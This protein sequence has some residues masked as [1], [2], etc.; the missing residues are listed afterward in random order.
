MGFLIDKYKD[1][2]RLLTEHDQSTNQFPR[3]LNGTFEDADVYIKCKNDIR[4]YYFGRSILEVYCPSV[5]RGMGIVRTI[6]R[7]FINKD[8][9]ETTFTTMTRDGKEVSRESVKIKNEALFQ[10]DIK[11]NDF[12]SNLVIGDGELSFRFHNKHM[13]EFEKYFSPSTSG[14]SISPFSSKNLPK[15]KSYV[16]PEEDLKMYKDITTSI[17]KEKMVVVAHITKNFIKSLAT[18]KNSYEK[19]KNDMALKCFNTK[20]YIHYIN[21]WREYIQYLTKEFNKLY[22][23]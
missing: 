1:K 20:Q 15:D 16:I 7:D 8:N 9:T 3:K 5:Q 10:S 18:K 21:K 14:A 19:I 13:E 12:I 22:E 2:Y 11:D 17:P 4:I 23:D 6:Y